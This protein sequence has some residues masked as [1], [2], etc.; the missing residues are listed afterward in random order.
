MPTIKWNRKIYDLYEFDDVI[1]LTNNIS[2]IHSSIKWIKPYEFE[3]IIIKLTELIKLV[4]R[5]LIL[6]GID[7]RLIYYK[8]LKKEANSFLFDIQ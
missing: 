2:N 6:D 7:E 1:D 8:M 5:Y 3:V 4:D